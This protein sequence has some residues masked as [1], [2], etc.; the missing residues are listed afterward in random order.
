MTLLEAEGLGYSVDG[1]TLVA[2]AG[3]TLDAGELTALIGPNGSGKTTLLRL[4]L[5]LLDRGTGSASIGGAAVES[6]TPV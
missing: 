2:D 3:F 4:A 5:G 6:L 1:R